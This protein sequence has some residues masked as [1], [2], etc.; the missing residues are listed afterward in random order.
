MFGI[1]FMPLFLNMLL[2]TQTFLSMKVEKLSNSW[3]ALHFNFYYI[4]SQDSVLLTLY[5]FFILSQRIYQRCIF[6]N[7]LCVHSTYCLFSYLVPRQRHPI[8]M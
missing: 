8:N 3:Q 6:V 4:F 2:S 1:I 5:S 7:V